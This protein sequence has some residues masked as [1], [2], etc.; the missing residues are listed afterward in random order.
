MVGAS[1]IKITLRDGRTR[2]IKKVW[3]DED[4]N[5]A[6]M[7]IEDDELPEIPMADIRN[8][9]I[10]QKVFVVPDSDDDSEKESVEAIV[11]DFKPVPGRRDQK[12][13]FIQVST[14][15]STR[16]TEKL[17]D[18]KGHFLGFQITEEKNIN[19]AAPASSFRD[20]I[21]DNK[22]TLVSDLK[23]VG[24]SGRALSLYMKGITARD[25]KQVD[26]AISYFK[27]AI[28]LNPRLLGARLE[29]SG[30]RFL[31]NSIR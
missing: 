1:I 25:R 21:K 29:Y 2:T 3:K 6:V 26:E 7:K 31:D 17:I 15:Q 28:K 12:A 22:P 19:L 9:K 30:P 13:Q 5:F 14:Q 16:Q 27:Q 10:G 23:H 11:C 8:I 20:L 24:F 4:Y 18:E